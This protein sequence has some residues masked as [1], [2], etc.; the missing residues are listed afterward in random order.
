MAAV[1]FGRRERRTKFHEIPPEVRKLIFVMAGSWTVSRMY[2]TKRYSATSVCRAWRDDMKGDAFAMGDMLIEAY[3]GS[4]EMAF[5]ASCTLGSDQEHQN[6][7]LYLSSKARAGWSNDNALLKAAEAGHESIVRL[8][9][10]LPEDAPRAD[11]CDGKALV[12]AAE[13]G[14]ERIVRLLLEWPEHA[15]R[16]DCLNGMA[17]RQSVRG[18][19]ESI[20]RLLWEWPVHAPVHAPQANDSDV[21]VAVIGGHESILRL[22]LELPEHEHAPR[23]DHMDGHY[24]ILAAMCGHES[25]VRLLLGWPEHAP[26]ADIRD[27]EALISAVMHDNVSIARTL[28]EWPEHAPRADCRNGEAFRHARGEAMIRLLSAN[29]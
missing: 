18:G 4:T 12:A 22:L 2:T 24:L 5:A 7:V 27:G 14:H 16:A 1:V 25:I 26:R 3:G 20:M 8:L 28:L 11:C 29:L 9:L 6:V 15:P 17:L 10:E 21:A 23:A 13:K 19:H